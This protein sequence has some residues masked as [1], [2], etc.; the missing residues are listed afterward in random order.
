MTGTT[1]TFTLTFQGER[2]T[3]WH[4][5]RPRRRS[6]PALEALP[7]IGAVN[8][9]AVPERDR[10]PNH[11]HRCAGRCQRAAHHRRR[12]R[13]TTAVVNPVYGLTVEKDVHILAARSPISNRRST[14]YQ[15]N[16]R[17]DRAMSSM[18]GFFSPTGSIA[19]RSR[20]ACRPSDRGRL[21]LHVSDYSLTLERQELAAPVAKQIVSPRS[22]K[23]ATGPPD[24]AGSPTRAERCDAT[25]RGVDHR[26]RQ[27]SLGRADRWLDA[28]QGPDGATDLITVR[29]APC[30][31][32]AR[33]RE[34][35]RPQ[36]HVL[37]GQGITP[38]LR[39]AR[40]RGRCSSLAGNNTVTGD[41]GWATFGGNSGSGSVSTIRSRP[42]RRR[43]TLTTTGTIS[44]FIGSGLNL[45][46]TA[47]G[48]RARERFPIDTG[49]IAERSSSDYA[50]YCIPIS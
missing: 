33:D 6:R 35:D 27:P 7:S 37:F 50:F 19:C 10:I 43:S 14:E 38:P 44:D 24:P 3:A 32:S 42:T 46:F 16:Q 15:R 30:C 41:I 22:N 39:D 11:V 48:D 45:R 26:P 23:F 4:S 40:S 1:G 12:D 47:A 36:Q 17:V 20:F 13:H 28:I 2:R 9:V 34:P 21:V 5:M 49:A 8:N 31:T 25:S 29:T 18:G